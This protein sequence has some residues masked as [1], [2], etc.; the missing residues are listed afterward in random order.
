LMGFELQS[1]KNRIQIK[2]G[3]DFMRLAVR[4]LDKLQRIN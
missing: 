3:G 1:N 2:F 4:I